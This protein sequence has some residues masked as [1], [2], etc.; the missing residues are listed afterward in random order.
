MSD[1]EAALAARDAEVAELRA[2]L[3]EQSRLAKEE[4]ARTC[5]VEADVQQAAAIHLTIQVKCN[6]DKLA[7]WL[8]F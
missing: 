2:Q 3:A 7:L 5:V 1:L 4:A 6:S 8:L